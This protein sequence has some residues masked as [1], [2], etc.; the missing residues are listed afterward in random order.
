MK[1]PAKYFCGPGLKHIPQQFLDRYINVFNDSF[2]IKTPITGETGIDGVLLDFN[3]GLRLQIPRGNWHVR[4]SDGASGIVFFDEDIEKKTLISMEKFFVEWEIAIWLDG[5]P[6]FYH[7][8]DPTGQ[9]VHF[10][11]KFPTLGDNTIYLPYI[12]EFQR[13]LDCEVSLSIP[14]VFHEI[15]KTYHPKIRL[16]KKLPPDA[17]ACYYIS[18]FM[19]LP[20]ASVSDMRTMSIA[21]FPSMILTSPKMHRPP[22]ANYAP[23]KPREI[24]EPYVC[25]GVQASFTPKCWLA[26]G[27]WDEV[28]EYLKLLGYRV[29]CIDR[30]RVCSNYGMTIEMPRGAEDFSGKYTLLDR[31][32]QLAY[33]DFFIGAS[34]GLSWLARAVGI[35]VVM[36]SGITEPWNEFDNPYRVNNPLVCHGC[37]NSTAIDCL[38]VLECMRYKG[39]E[40]M[41]ECSKKISARQVINA[42]DQL[43]SDRKLTG[44]KIS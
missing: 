36:I 17:Y 44:G 16:I 5:E 38:K 32:N 11:I 41:Y 13:R 29:L 19:N 3:C 21:D 23:T 15:V 42:I 39:T 2:A 33:A 43:V 22:K 24:L 12:E 14:E 6:V 8:F 1:Y 34:S 7:L 26:P 37:F 28:V 30:D 40:R 4:I 18:G 27:G 10:V 35:P 31:I 20:I 25:I 9:Q